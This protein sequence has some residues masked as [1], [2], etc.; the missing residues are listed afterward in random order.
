MLYHDTS[1]VNCFFF[2][3]LLGAHVRAHTQSGLLL[4]LERGTREQQ[5]IT[6]AAAA[7]TKAHKYIWCGRGTV[8]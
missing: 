2:V 6:S 8:G 7:K 1:P 5:F 4:T 3:R